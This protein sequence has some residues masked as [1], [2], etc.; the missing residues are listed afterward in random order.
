MSESGLCTALQNSA[1][2]SS[3]AVVR[4]LVQ[5]E[6]HTDTPIDLRIATGHTAAEM[7]AVL[8]LEQSSHG[9]AT[10][11]EESGLVTFSSDLWF[12]GTAELRCLV[13]NRSGSATFVVVQIDV[14]PP[15]EVH[16][17]TASVL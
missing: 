4:I 7:P 13:E 2:Q 9:Q 12:E 11:S 8:I 15:A 17:G 16:P 1:E 6:S 14:Q 10:V 5:A 3:T